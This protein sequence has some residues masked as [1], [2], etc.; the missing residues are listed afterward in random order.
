MIDVRVEV[1]MAAVGDGMLGEAHGDRCSSSGVV[2][3][4]VDFFLVVVAEMVHGVADDARF[5]LFGAQLG[6]DFLR[7]DEADFVVDGVELFLQSEGER[8]RIVGVVMGGTVVHCHRMMMMLIER[9]FL[10]GG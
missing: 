4:V 9:V 6:V 7:L 1:R 10:V 3:V 8:L 5:E 2:V